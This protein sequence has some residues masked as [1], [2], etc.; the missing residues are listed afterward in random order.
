LRDLIASPQLEQFR[1]RVVVSYHLMPLDAPETAAYINSRLEHAS[2]AAP[3]LR[4][5]ADAA[6]LVHRRSGGVPRIINVICDAALVF[7]YAEERRQIDL[8]LIRDV[9]TE[10]EVTGILA[11]ERAGRSLP[12][13]APASVPASAPTTASA[14]AAARVPDLRPAVDT[15][16]AAPPASLLPP[17][18]PSRPTQPSVVLPASLREDALARAAEEAAQRASLLATREHAI[19]RREREL[20]EQRRVLAEEYRLLRTRRPPAAAPSATAR[21]QG[22]AAQPPRFTASRPEGVMAWFRHLLSGV[23]LRKNEEKLGHVTRS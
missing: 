3:P 10:L 23:W 5:P 20:A 1:Q 12:E 15:R 8:A 22:R 19:A 21:T 7:G 9:V 11:A 4:F 2:N 14:P 18:A 16:P 17:V 6:E 13:I